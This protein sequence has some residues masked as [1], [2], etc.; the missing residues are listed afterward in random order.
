[1][2]QLIKYGE[3][4]FPTDSGVVSHFGYTVYR[5]QPEQNASGKSHD[6]L[7]YAHLFLL[8]T[9]EESDS[10]PSLRTTAAYPA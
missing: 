5:F 6:P 10:L 3:I 1:M 2:I 7:R 8:G 4:L 9:V